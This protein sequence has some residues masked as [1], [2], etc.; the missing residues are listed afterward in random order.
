MD[1]ER[2][3]RAAYF[4]CEKQNE[5]MVNAGTAALF[6]AYFPMTYRMAAVVRPTTLALWTGAY[7]F[8]LYKQ[9]LQPMALWQFQASL[10]SA[11]RPF[12]AKYNVGTEF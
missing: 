2:E 3:L 9:G 10:N 8:G 7:Y 11:A 4:N 6:I 5:F 1:D 12:A